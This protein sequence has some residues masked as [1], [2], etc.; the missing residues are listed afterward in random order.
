MRP[1]AIWFTSIGVISVALVATVPLSQAASK[2]WKPEVAHAAKVTA[3]LV[4]SKSINP[5]SL[6]R[7]NRNT[8]SVVQPTQL[9]TANS[10]VLIRS[11]STQPSSLDYPATTQPVSHTVSNTELS[12]D[13]DSS[14]MTD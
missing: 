12:S 5:I 8:S 1:K 6:A 3:H 11:T 7:R 2:L 4:K 10:E 14:K 13:L 9:P